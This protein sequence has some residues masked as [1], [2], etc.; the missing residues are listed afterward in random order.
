MDPTRESSPESERPDSGSPTALAA[1]G[2]GA[3]LSPEEMEFVFEEDQGDR[4]RYRRLQRRLLFSTIF[5]GAV[6][7]FALSMMYSMLDDV[8]YWFQDDA[9]PQEL[10]MVDVLDQGGSLQPWQDHYVALSGTPDALTAVKVSLGNDD[11]V[12]QKLRFFRLLE[13]GNRVFV[14]TD[15]QLDAD[16]ESDFALGGV[17]TKKLP[18]RFVGRVHRLGE[19]SF[20]SSLRD[21]YNALA[22]PEIFKLDRPSWPKLH[23]ENLGQELSAQ[24]T[25]EPDAP[26]RMLKLADS[27]KFEVLVLPAELEVQLGTKTW[28]KEAA[29]IE[30]VKSLGLPFAH[31]PYKALPLAG[32]KN[33]ERVVQGVQKQQ[34]HRFVVRPQGRSAKEIK[35]ALE[36]GLEIPADNARL[37]V[38]AGVHGRRHL[39]TVA[40]DK[41]KVQGER[42]LFDPQ[43]KAVSPGYEL[44]GGQLRERKWGPQGLEIPLQE[45]AELRVRRPVMATENS[46]IVLTDSPPSKQWP[47]ALAFG[48]LA[49]FSVANVFMG[50][51]FYRRYTQLRSAANDD[52]E[53]APGEEG[54]S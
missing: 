47:T 41:L 6:V 5:S 19:V 13:A 36:Q 23:G 17:Q 54:V 53:V 42:M 21:H 26:A 37:E 7:L 50:F 46:M 39:Y 24:S 15:L 18:G 12:T 31:L 10:A 11:K 2:S 30:R 40:I 51:R 33:P 16:P 9:A 4:A 28:P 27:D 34:M 1:S 22:R 49:V 35:A 20:Y 45:V 14:Q 25:R 29:A 3:G 8:A 44:A 48:I 52:L 38:G 32:S 43:S